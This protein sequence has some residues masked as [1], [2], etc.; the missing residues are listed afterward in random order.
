MHKNWIYLTGFAFIV[1]A[2]IVSGILLTTS[3]RHDAK[4]EIP[5]V[6]NISISVLKKPVSLVTGEMMDISYSLETSEFEGNDLSLTRVEV[7]NEDTGK[8]IRAFEDDALRQIYTRADGGK[9]PTITIALEVQKADIPARI[10]H[11]LSFISDGRA[12]LPFSVTGGEIVV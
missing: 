4:D 5:D 2:L 10:I 3:D 12:I 6:R 8:I 7:L 9:N 1:I 11:R